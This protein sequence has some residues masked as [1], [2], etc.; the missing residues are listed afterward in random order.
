MKKLAL[1]S[2]QL[3]AFLRIAVFFCLLLTAYCQLS[4]SIP[5]MESQQCSEARDSVKEFY[6]WYLGTDAE[7]RK[8]QPE[9]YKKYIAE[10]SQLNASGAGIDPFFNSET[11]PTTFKIGQCEAVDDSHTNIQVQ[12]YWRYSEQKVDQKELYVDTIKNGDRWQIEKI[13][14]R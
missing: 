4:C 6:S 1:G 3:A 11:A 9:I 5:N 12:L 10:R 2:R 7:Q 13:E 14:S 8:K